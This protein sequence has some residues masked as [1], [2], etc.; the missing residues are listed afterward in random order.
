[1]IEML[2]RIEDFDGC[3]PFFTYFEGRDGMLG[4]LRIDDQSDGLIGSESHFF[5]KKHGRAAKAFV[6]GRKCIRALQTRLGLPEF[7]LTPGEFGP[8]WPSD[9]VGS[10]SHSR[11]LAAATIIR[12]VRGVGVDIER[13]RRLKVNAVRRVATKEE[14]SRYSAVPDFD[15]TLL[16]SAKESVFKAFSPLAR[17]Y[18][19]FQEVE[20][21][22]DTT[23]KSFS[24]SYL[25]NTIDKGLFEKSEGHW[26]SLAGHVITVVMLK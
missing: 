19:G 25:G 14:Y 23:T 13:Q 12:D 16:F 3:L 24:L 15:W 21:L 9:L 1:M 6:S 11:E 7:E 22:L 10:I 2:G 18:I 5:T 8:I 17:R 4:F 20:L 26:S